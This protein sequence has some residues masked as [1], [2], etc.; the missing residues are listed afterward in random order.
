MS[1]LTKCKTCDEQINQGS[2]WVDEIKRAG[3]ILLISVG[4]SFVIGF[5]YFLTYFTFF[6][7]KTLPSLQIFDTVFVST[8]Q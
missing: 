6:S 8:S 7:I 5:V 4:I 1:E 3:P 2:N